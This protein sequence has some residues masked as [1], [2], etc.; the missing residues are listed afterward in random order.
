MQAKAINRMVRI[1]PSKV[2]LVIDLVR[3]KPVELH[4]YQDA[5][6]HP[7]LDSP[8]QLAGPK[9]G[10]ADDGWASAQRSPRSNPPLQAPPCAW[11]TAV[12]TRSDRLFQSLIP[13]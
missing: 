10:A 11:E 12:S 4:L 7:I 9:V 3:G 8:R 6:G 2:R 13:V 5:F 1:A